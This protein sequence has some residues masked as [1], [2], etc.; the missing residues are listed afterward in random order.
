M[1]AHDVRS[2]VAEPV[3]SARHRIDGDGWAGLVLGAAVVAMA[4]VAGLIYTFSVAVM[5]NL[6]D[7]DDRT[8]VATMQRFNENP[9]FQLSFTGALALTALAAV[10]QRRRGPEVAVR[11]TVAA[12]VLYGIVFAV[13]LGVNVPLNDE[14][15]RAGDPDRIA[16]LGHVRNQFEG[17]WVAAN[18]VRT[19][20]CT[21]AVAALARALLLHGRSTTDRTAAASAGGSPWAPPANTYLAGSP[22]SVE[23]SAR[24][25][26]V[27]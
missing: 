5:P 18:I 13:T 16:D 12:L 9:A 11:W 2:P 6:A 8:F 17:P 25:R 10:L 1:T 21:A 15:D 20:L 26:S 14:I 23:P 19:L 7:A 22:P 4:L 27:R 3:R 24:A